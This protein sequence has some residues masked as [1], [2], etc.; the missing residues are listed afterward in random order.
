MS[1]FLDDAV[2]VESDDDR[3]ITVIGSIT[4]SIP[5]DYV[6][7]RPLFC[8]VCFRPMRFAD[9]VSSYDDHNCCSFCDIHFARPNREKWKNGWRPPREDIE[10]LIADRHLDDLPK[11]LLNG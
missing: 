8:P 5:R 9:D 1:L 3:K 2:W 6:N 7:P 10:A 11:T 4:I